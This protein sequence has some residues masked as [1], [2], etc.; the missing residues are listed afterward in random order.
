MLSS[1]FLWNGPQSA[2]A[3]THFCHSRAA[4]GTE[5]TASIAWSV[6][7]KRMRSNQ[8]MADSFQSIISFDSRENEDKLKQTSQV[9]VFLLASRIA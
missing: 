3:H 6:Q 5:K 4:Q 7:S 9:L 8:N 1:M 2:A